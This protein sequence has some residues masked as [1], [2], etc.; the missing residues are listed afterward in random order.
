MLPVFLLPKHHASFH[1][2]REEEHVIPIQTSMSRVILLSCTYSLPLRLKKNPWRREMKF[3]A[4]SWLLTFWEIAWIKVFRKNT[5]YMCYSSV[6]ICQPFREHCRCAASSSWASSSYFREIPSIA[7][8]EAAWI[9]HVC[10]VKIL[11]GR[12]CSILIRFLPAETAIIF[13]SPGFSLRPCSAP[14]FTCTKWGTFSG[15]GGWKTR[16]TRMPAI[17]LWKNGRKEQRRWS[18]REIS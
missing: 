14:V 17:T 9:S 4:Y 5:V 12:I 2:K 7:E 13:L 11:N 10:P 1:G 15:G 18:Q 6:S 8:C 16:L 3:Q